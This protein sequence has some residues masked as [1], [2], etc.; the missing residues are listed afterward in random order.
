MQSDCKN[1]SV[2]QIYKFY[3]LSW[4]QFIQERILILIFFSNNGYPAGRISNEPPLP[5]L[6]YPFFGYAMHISNTKLQERFQ[7]EFQD[8]SWSVTQRISK[9]PPPSKLPFSFFFFIIMPCISQ[10]PIS[11]QGRIPGFSMVSDLGILLNT[12]QCINGVPHIKHKIFPCL[13]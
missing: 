13:S 10:I 7:K 1:G 8:F 12:H 9:G 3:I 4:K 2:L 6:P 5:K 11:R